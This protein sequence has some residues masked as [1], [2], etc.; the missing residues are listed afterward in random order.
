MNRPYSGWNVGIGTLRA[1]LVEK[2]NNVI[3]RLTCHRNPNR[4]HPLLNRASRGSPFVAVIVSRSCLHCQKIRPC[5]RPDM[6]LI[7]KIRIVGGWTNLVTPEQLVTGAVLQ[8]VPDVQ[9]L[10][11]SV[12]SNMIGVFFRFIPGQRSAKIQETHDLL[13]VQGKPSREISSSLKRNGQ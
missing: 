13:V 5:T 4:Y 11:D 2:D 9:K 3:A 6:T 7:T 10:S 12:V 1:G 8:S